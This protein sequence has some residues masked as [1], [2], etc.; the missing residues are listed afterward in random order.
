MNQKDKKK[1]LSNAFHEKVMMNK[2]KDNY[3]KEFD[4]MR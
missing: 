3:S 1:N 4:H 2:M